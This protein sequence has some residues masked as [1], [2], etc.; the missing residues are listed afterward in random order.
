MHINLCKLEQVCFTPVG[1]VVVLHTLDVNPFENI[2]FCWATQLLY[3]QITYG[4]KVRANN[5]RL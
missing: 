2:S 1:V 3:W 5:L 4:I